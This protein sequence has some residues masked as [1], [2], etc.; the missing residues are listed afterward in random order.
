[1]SLHLGQQPN[2]VNAFPLHGKQMEMGVYQE[3]RNLLHG[4]GILEIGGSCKTRI[5]LIPLGNPVTYLFV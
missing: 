3:W 5:G 4:K 2:N 1:M